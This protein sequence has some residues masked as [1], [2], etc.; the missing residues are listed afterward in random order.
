MAIP[1]SVERRKNPSRKRE[2]AFDVTD[3]VLWN[4]AH[5]T[6]DV[7]RDEKKTGAFA[8]DKPTAVGLAIRSA[9]EEDRA[10][11]IQVKSM[12]GGKSTVEWSR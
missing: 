7:Y 5:R 2:I 1:P 3:W 11:R 6:F 9:Q 4:D 12:Q 8:R 10:L